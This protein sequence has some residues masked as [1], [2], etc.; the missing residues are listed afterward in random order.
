LMITWCALRR[1]GCGRSALFSSKLEGS[2]FGGGCAYADTEHPRFP[3]EL[4][5]NL[6]PSGRP[7]R[8]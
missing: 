4:I 3:V 5:G 8:S 6:I 7:K 2:N 1:Q